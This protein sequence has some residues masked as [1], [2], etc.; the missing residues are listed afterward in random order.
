M[1]HGHN[2]GNSNSHVIDGRTSPLRL[3]MLLHGPLAQNLYLLPF[4]FHIILLM[5]SSIHIDHIQCL[6]TLHSP[7]KVHSTPNTIITLIRHIRVTISITKEDA[8]T[9]AFF[10]QL[11]DHRS[12]CRTCRTCGT[13][14]FPTSFFEP[15]IGLACP[16]IY[17]AFRKLVARMQR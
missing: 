6:T 10:S 3:F 8:L 16:E 1:Q 11:I 2:E 9:H 7:F 14:R 12:T 13:F 15:A 4:V 5:N 17:F